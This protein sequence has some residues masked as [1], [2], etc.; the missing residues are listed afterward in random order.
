VPVQLYGLP[1]ATP[2]KIK[3]Q[4]FQYANTWSTV[5]ELAFENEDEFEELQK[6]LAD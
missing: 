1:D 4:P 3:L 6:L 2:L 5:L